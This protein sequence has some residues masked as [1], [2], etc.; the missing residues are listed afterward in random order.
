M[1]DTAHTNTDIHL[2]SVFKEQIVKCLVSD[3]G[4]IERTCA[5][6]YDASLALDKGLLV[7]FLKTIQPDVWQSLE[8]HYSGSAES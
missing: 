6:D 5:T 7:Q 4:Y 1:T 3:Q 8:D 2:E